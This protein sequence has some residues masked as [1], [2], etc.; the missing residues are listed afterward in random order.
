MGMIDKSK[1]AFLWVTDFPMFEY[2]DAEQRWG[3][4]HHPFTSPRAEVDMD[5]LENPTRASALAQAYD[6]VVNGIELGGGS[7]RIHRS[8]VQAKVFS[9]LGL[10]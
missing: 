3:A 9:L 7:I 8:D 2:D 5:K 1:W 10:S 6:L 4:M